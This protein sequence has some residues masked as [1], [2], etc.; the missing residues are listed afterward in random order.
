MA[1]M[2]ALIALVA[3]TIDNSILIVATARTAKA[4]RPFHLLKRLLTLPLCA[5]ELSELTERK[6]LLEL[7]AASGHGVKQ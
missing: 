1:A 4:I 5:I 7:D 6:T 3:P 2:S